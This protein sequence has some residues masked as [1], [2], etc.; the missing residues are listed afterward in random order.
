MAVNSKA[1]KTGSHKSSG[2]K[3]K[4]FSAGPAPSQSAPPAQRSGPAATGL[5]MA[6]QK[7]LIIR[8]KKVLAPLE[9]PSSALTN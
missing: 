4:S 9:D 6:G 7:A 3:A 2:L 5:G 1:D 8:A